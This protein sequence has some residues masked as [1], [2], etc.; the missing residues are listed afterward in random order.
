MNV[1]KKQLPGWCEQALKN[2]NNELRLL[3]GFRSKLNCVFVRGET[4]DGQKIYLQLL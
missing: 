1:V 2:K 4:V 3:S